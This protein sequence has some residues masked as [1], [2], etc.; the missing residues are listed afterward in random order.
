MVKYLKLNIIF[1]SIKNSQKYSK[2]TIIFFFNKKVTKYSKLAITTKT[3]VK[4]I[5]F[6]II[7][8]HKINTTLI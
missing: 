4:N 2:L 5:E 6:I 1:F 8:S 3:H 7:Q